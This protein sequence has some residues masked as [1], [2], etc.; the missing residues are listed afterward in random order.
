VDTPKIEP[1][2][3]ETPILAPLVVATTKKE[4]AKPD[5]GRK[6]DTIPPIQI[7]TLATVTTKSGR[8]SKPSTPALATFQEAARSRSSRNADGSGTNK[9][10]K[11]VTSTAQALAA[12]TAD[13]DASSSMQGDDEGGDVD[14]DELTYCYCNGVSYGEMVACDADGCERE[15]FHLECVGLKVAPKGNGKL[16]PLDDGLGLFTHDLLLSPSYLLSSES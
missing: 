8:A 1:P 11:K 10:T 14:A 5:E 3:V 6:S 16:L 15:W 9:R 12:Q 2:P 4:P 13:E 7:N